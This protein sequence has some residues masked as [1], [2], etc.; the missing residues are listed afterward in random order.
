LKGSIKKREG[1]K[2]EKNGNESGRVTMFPKKFFGEPFEYI[3][4][5]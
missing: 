2:K 1:R 4:D 5:P 3:F